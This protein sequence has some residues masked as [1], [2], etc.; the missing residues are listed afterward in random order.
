MAKL[1][2]LLTTAA[3]LVA[4]VQAA[5]CPANRRLCGHTLIDQYQ[6]QFLS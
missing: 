2:A 1:F 6:C 5:G 4:G 3:A